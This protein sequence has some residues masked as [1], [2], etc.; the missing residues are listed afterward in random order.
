[1]TDRFCTFHSACHTHAQWRACCAGPEHY[2]TYP[3]PQAALRPESAAVDTPLSR[4]TGS[5][6]SAELS[7]GSTA[8]LDSGPEEMPE[9]PEAG[10]SWSLTDGHFSVQSAAFSACRSNFKLL[11]SLSKSQVSSMQYCLAHTPSCTTSLICLDPPPT[12]HLQMSAGNEENEGRQ[13]NSQSIGA[14]QEEEWTD[15][16]LQPSGDLNKMM[17]QAP[18]PAKKRILKNKLDA[19]V[20]ARSRKVIGMTCNWSQQCTYS[21]FM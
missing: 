14:A 1:M 20:K 9:I 8:S 6:G 21:V 12:S 15:I 10:E 7:Y 19:A 16:Q 11:L 2:R 4:S 3:I 13:G 18:A 5:N 17:E